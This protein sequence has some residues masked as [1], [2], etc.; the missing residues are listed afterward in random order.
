M[1]NTSILIY[2]VHDGQTGVEVRLDQDTVWLTQAQIID[3]FESSKANISEHIKHI[4]K[5]GE[6]P[7]EATVRKFRTVP[8]PCSG[9]QLWRSAKADHWPIESVDYSIYSSSAFGSDQIPCFIKHE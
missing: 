8:R 9:K 7:K 1:E 4:F 5:S 6:L 2:Q 3:L